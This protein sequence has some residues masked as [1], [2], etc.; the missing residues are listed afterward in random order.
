MRPPTQFFVRYRG[1]VAILW[2]AI[3]AVLAAPSSLEA[4][5]DGQLS[6]VTEVKGEFCKVKLDDDIQVKQ[7][8]K[9]EL[10]HKKKKSTAT[11]RVTAIRDEYFVVKTSDGSVDV[12]A[13]ATLPGATKSSTGKSKSKSKNSSKT[14]KEKPKS[15]K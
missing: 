10:Y 8:Q 12:G 9:V 1:P 4:A 3:I 5:D 14:A 15:R 2:L 6:V 13:L 11:G 7:G